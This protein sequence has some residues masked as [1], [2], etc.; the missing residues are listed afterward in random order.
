M[1]LYCTLLEQEWWQGE[2]IYKEN[3]S[4]GFHRMWMLEALAQKTDFCINFQSID[5][6]YYT[7][8][9]LWSRTHQDKI[10]NAYTI[11]RTLLSNE[12]VLDFDH[13][14]YVW[15]VFY[16][17][18]VHKILGKLGYVP[19]IY[20]SGNKGLHVHYY[21]DYKI[22]AEKLDMKLQKRIIKHFANKSTFEKRLTKFIVKRYRGLF[23]QNYVDASLIHTSHTIRS[24]GSLNKKGFKTFLGNDPNFI[25][26]IPPIYNIENERYP[27]F[28]FHH[29]C[30]SD[31]K[32]K[33]SVPTNV[34]KLCEDF[35]RIKRIGVDPEE[36][37]SLFDY[38]PKEETNNDEVKK[39]CIKF[40]ESSEF[41]KVSECRKRVLFV[42]ASHYKENA[43]QLT[44]LR[45][46][47]ASILD[48]YLRDDLIF[49]TLKSTTGNV[50]CN[51][52]KHILGMIGKSDIC[53]G[54]S[55]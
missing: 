30:Y 15:N 2:P 12:F 22:L 51:Y 43:D 16:F 52:I 55:R 1:R 8:R 36:S 32:I 29:Y 33:Y 10:L 42:L 9:E 41:S 21:L 31:S 38:F 7:K 40:F 18:Q 13:K 37:R 49:R 26:S 25:P 39:N 5:G 48:G 11:H 6:K 53:K 24:E 19:Y 14:D 23:D 28:P 20:F 35:V 54:C 3:E 17:K 34:V 4:V 45:R 44:I 46:W 50:G 27:K 47:N